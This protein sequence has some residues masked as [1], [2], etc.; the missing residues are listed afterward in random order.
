MKKCLDKYA[1]LII[2]K[3]V[4]L[5]PDQP[6]IVNAPVTSYGLVRQ[7]CEKAYEA[8][9]CEV[10]INWKDDLIKRYDLEY[11]SE[12]RLSKPHSWFIDARLEPIKEGAAVASIASPTPKYL[13][14]VDSQKVNLANEVLDRALKPFYDAT[15]SDQNEWCVFADSNPAWAKAVFPELDE[16]EAED[17]LWD[18]ILKAVYID[19]E[20][21]A[22]AAWDEHD[23]LLSERCDKLNQKAFKALHFKNEKGTNLYVGLPEGHI[24]SGGGEKSQKGVFFNANMPTEEIFTAPMKWQVNGKVVATKPL[25]HSGSLIENFWF[26]FKDGKVID[27]CAE[28]EADALKRILE[29]DEGSCYLGE[30]ALVEHESPISQSGILFYNTLFDE[31]A[32]C[33][34]ALG[35]AYPLSVEGGCEMSP[36]KMAEVG[37]NDSIKHVDFMF[38]DETMCIRGLDQDGNETLIFENGRFV[39]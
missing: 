32:S 33:H 39:L 7:L 11:Q 24:W 30:V 6:L 29:A 16:K 38:G 3:G 1:E 14:G 34:L 21:D 2:K 9:A 35:A 27:F 36:E 25:D 12:E 17:K 26:E 4:N 20:N 18:A 15:R 22:M 13:K 19:E 5:Q 37:V 31:N 8:G 10:Y 28:K 23:R